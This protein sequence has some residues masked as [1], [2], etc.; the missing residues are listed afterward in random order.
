MST[1]QLRF[2]LYGVVL[3]VGV[4]LGSWFGATQLAP[5]PDDEAPVC[6][7]APDERGAPGP[8]GDSGLAPWEQRDQVYRDL[9]GG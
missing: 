1:V 9:F 3:A 7:Y 4:A 6:T 8:P 2:F 5:V